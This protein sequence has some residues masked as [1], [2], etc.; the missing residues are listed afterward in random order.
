MEPEAMPL[1]GTLDAA[2]ATQAPL[3][4]DLT[5]CQRMIREL[6]D[7]LHQ[8]QHERDQLERRLDQLLRRLYGPKGERFD[9]NAP[10][11]FDAVPQLPAEPAPVAPPV[12]EESAPSKK[13]GH[14]RKELP[15]HLR[16]EQRIHD[17]SETEK[18]CPCCGKPRTRIG[19]ERSERLD[20]E[21][22]KPFVVEHIRPK[23]ACLECLKKNEQSP[24]ETPPAQPLIVTAPLPAA[25]IDKG[26]PEPGMLAY[27]LVS[28]YVDHLPLH[29]QISIFER[30]GLFLSRS[31]LC[32]WMKAA[33]DL[34]TPLYELLS[35][36]V[37]L[38]KVIHT[39]DTRVPVQ[40]PG[41]KKT[42]SGRLWVYIGDREHPGVVY[43]Y[44]PT[45]ARDGPATFLKNYRGFLQADAA[46]LYDGLYAPAKIIEVGCW[47]HARRHFFE[48]KD[49]D[50]TRAH[51]ALARIGAL[52]AVEDE[53]AAL[54]AQETLEGA[55]ADALRLRVRRE[56]SVPL[57][58]TLAQW[59]REQQP[60]VLPK[61]PIGQA[62]AYTLRHGQAL[63]RYTEHGFLDIDNNAAERALRAVAIG[64]KNWLFAGS[65]EGGKTAAKL[66][67][68][69]ATCKHLGIDPFIYLRHVLKKLPELRGQANERHEALLPDH[70]AQAQREQLG[71][72]A[73]S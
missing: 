6:L 20:C 31:T 62:I 54:I 11:L 12:I 67:T 43:E 26:L 14:G 13:P 29:R 70:W 32:D 7:T 64:R 18:L 51:E 52:Y 39:D 59:L 35:A 42:K 22:A 34:L 68:I 10:T 28:K 21:P 38:S 65:D 4:D 69:T 44:T 36:R 24:P 71:Q 5:T 8:T 60:L 17:L 53:A 9:P 40:E 16:R 63:H 61:S 33:A 25:A 46:N 56:K 49:T 15:K 48:A 66:Y 19:E 47:A 73:Q 41:Q 2:H 58:D 55:A 30:Q 50:A 23:Y 27:V 3:P 1:D 37:L 45:H 72:P 57:L